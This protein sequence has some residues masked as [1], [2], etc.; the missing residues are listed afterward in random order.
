MNFLAS[1][2]NATKIPPIVIATK[3]TE[4]VETPETNRIG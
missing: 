4:V 2:N 1:I 3:Q